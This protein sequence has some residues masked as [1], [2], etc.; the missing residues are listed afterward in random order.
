LADIF[1]RIANLTLTGEG[2]LH[3][4][5]EVLWSPFR[6]A[7]LNASMTLRN[8]KL[9]AGGLKFENAGSPQNREIPWQIDLVGIDNNPWQITCGRLSMTAPVSLVLDRIDAAVKTNAAGFEGTGNYSVVLQPSGQ[10]GR[11]PSA[12][13]I[14][15]PLPMQGR[16]SAAYHSPGKWQVQVSNENN[17]ESSAKAVRLYVDPYT[18]T[19]ARPEL[20]LSAEAEPQKIEAA[21]LFTAPDVR[22]GSASG[23]L[24]TPRL[25]FKSAADLAEAGEADARITFELQAPNTGL[26]SNGV[27][28]KIPQISAAGKLN[29]DASRHISLSGVLQFTGSGQFSGLNARITGARGKI[30]FK[31]PVEGK[32]EKGSISIGGLILKDM[33][34]GGL[35]SSLRQTATGFVFEGQHQS[36][37]VPNLK[38]DFTG[39]SRLFKVASRE[40]NIRV[41]ISRPD[42]APEID[43]GKLVPDAE[44]FQIKGKFGLN[45]DFKLNDRG[46]GGS[47][48]ADFNE[49]RLRSAKNK[50]ALEGIRISLNL[51]ELPRIR[52]DPGQRIQFSKFSLGDLTVEKGAID[53]QIESARSFLVEKMHF[54][55][56]DG[57]VETQSMR[58]S[59]GIEDYRI[60]FYCD[61]LNLAK[62][63]QQF[64]AAAAEGGGTVNGRIPLQYANG[65][66]NFDDGFLFSSPGE[67][68]KIRITGSDILTAGIPPDT[69]QYVQMELASEALKD[70]D[71]SW[72]K[73]NI[74]SQG[75]ELLLQ[76]QMDGKPARTLPFVYR[77]DIGGFVKVEADA[78]GSMFQGIRLDVNFRLPLNKLLQYKNLINMIK[79]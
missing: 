8:F 26:T 43:L 71:Y 17:E 10:T 54:Q 38:M 66:I 60:I 35:T 9:I 77:K 5:A 78:K 28:I 24:Y 69:P 64:G 51:S 27:E 47:L 40:S 75:D 29:R 18:I 41:K 63:L 32:T 65:K 57:Q 6:M 45:G 50:L 2:G 11:N 68:G 48:R 58:L 21:C 13:K 61:R 4:K 44:G 62:V 56:C 73:L 55:W 79:K 15:D 12:V 67:G 33:N 59:P 23:S 14:L 36:S 30:P 31:W 19:L 1:G 53:F 52:S 46:F 70:Y 22:I 7:S 25:V 42:D 39:E 74:T 20:S 49:G 34:L 3:A 37:L 76:M 16:F 72:A